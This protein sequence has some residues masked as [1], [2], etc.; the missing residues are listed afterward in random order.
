MEWFSE[1]VWDKPQADA[2]EGGLGDLW[3]PRV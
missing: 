3:F 1:Q 2:K